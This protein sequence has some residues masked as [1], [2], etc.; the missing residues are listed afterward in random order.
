MNL[1]FFGES[2]LN[3]TGFGAVNKHLLA[4]FSREAD[5]TC[6]ASGHYHAGYDRSMY[7]YEIVGCPYIPPDQRTLEH[8]RNLYNIEKHIKKA[9]WDVFATQVDLGWWNDTVLYWAKQVQDAHPEKQTIFYFPIDGD[10]SLPHAFTPLSWCSVPVVYTNHAKSVVERYAPE[11]GKDVSVMW[12]GCEPDIFYPMSDEKKREMRLKFFGPEYLD[13]FIVINTNRNQARKDLMRSMALF[14]EFHKTHPD[15]TLY[16]HTVPNDIGGGIEFQGRLVGIDHDAM[17]KELICSN[18]DLAH[19]WARS[20]LNELY[21]ACDCLIST[22]H[23]EGWGLNTTDAMCAGVPVVV[24]ANTANLDILGNGPSG[25][26]GGWEDDDYD[27]EPIDEE[28]EYERGWGVKMGGDLDHTV[29]GYHNGNSVSSIVH[30]ESFLKALKYVYEHR[31]EA[32]A[33]AK[34]A[35]AWCVENSWQ[36][37]EEEWQKLIRLMKTQ[38][39]APSQHITTP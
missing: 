17:P 31:E 29:Y 4:A 1:L 25:L 26:V 15:S 39:D 23:G 27:F 35:R 37:R 7:P 38:E 30:A 16:L 10:V 20:T 22:A 9:E 11:I 3:P 5:V 13:R 21:N 24:P 34:H 36:K 2:P 19:P 18:L 32:V 28:F 8:Q 14:H 12:L 33:K 6:V